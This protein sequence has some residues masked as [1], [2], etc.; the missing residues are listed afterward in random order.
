MVVILG[1]SQGTLYLAR[2]RIYIESPHHPACCL[3]Q[4]FL[5]LEP[6]GVGVGDQK[7][8]PLMQQHNRYQVQTR[9]LELRHQ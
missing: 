6:I 2:K 3:R 7:K 4:A 8:N 5:W 9:N 1:V